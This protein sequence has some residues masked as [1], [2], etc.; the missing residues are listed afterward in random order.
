MHPGGTCIGCHASEGEGPSF[1]IAGTVYAAPNEATDCFGAADIEVAITTADGKSLTVGTNDAGNFTHSADV[2][3]PL[4]VKVT[5]GDKS[6]EMASPVTSGEC[7]GCHTETGEQGAP[8][9]ILA[10]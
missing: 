4:Q 5:R 9:R 2:V 6:V 7:N 3:F 8:G 1:R 10:P